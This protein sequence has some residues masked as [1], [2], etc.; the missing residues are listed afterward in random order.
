MILSLRN[1]ISRLGGQLKDRTGASASDLPHYTFKEV[2]EFVCFNHADFTRSLTER[3][4][5]RNN[6]C[7]RPQSDDWPNV[8]LQS[9]PPVDG[10][11][12]PSSFSCSILMREGPAPSKEM[13]CLAKNRARFSEPA[14][15]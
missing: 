13:P 6:T 4:G 9:F 3:R 12:S 5:I 8:I 15:L 11:N 1:G 14:R 10:V 2:H 7:L